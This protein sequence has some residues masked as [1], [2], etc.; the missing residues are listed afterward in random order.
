MCKHSLPT[1][2]LPSPVSSHLRAKQVFPKTLW[3]QNRAPLREVL[4]PVGTACTPNKGRCHLGYL[5][6]C[7]YAWNYEAGQECSAIYYTHK[8][9]RTHR[10]I[11][12]ATP[13]IWKV[14][15]QSGLQ[16][17]LTTMRRPV[18]PTP[19]E[20]VEGEE[21]QGLGNV[22]TEAFCLPC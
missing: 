2:S 18:K 9:T 5:T 17:A 3:C 20:E 19:G 6:N 1:P 8:H 12:S 16:T 22:Q 10:N 13:F 15:S 4:Q 21:K 7:N 11:C 14:F